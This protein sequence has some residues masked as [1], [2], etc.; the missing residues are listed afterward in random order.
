MHQHQRWSNQRLSENIEVPI[1][2]HLLTP[3]SLPN[4]VTRFLHPPELLT[5]AETHQGE[6]KR[7]DQTSRSG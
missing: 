1:L 6:N 5:L 7:Q 3:R 2:K 4:H